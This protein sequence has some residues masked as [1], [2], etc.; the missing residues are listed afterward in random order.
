MENQIQKKVDSKID[1][2][3]WFA[4]ADDIFTKYCQRP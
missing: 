1:K 3:P 4:E 2:N